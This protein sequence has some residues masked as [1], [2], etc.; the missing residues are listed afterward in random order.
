MMQ[1]KYRLCLWF[2]ACLLVSVQGQGD[3]P[4]LRRQ[5]QDLPCLAPIIERIDEN[6]PKTVEEALSLPPYESPEP[7][8]L[9]DVE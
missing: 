2:L 8:A 6:A 1:T 9:L 7:G 4:S 5:F 3:F